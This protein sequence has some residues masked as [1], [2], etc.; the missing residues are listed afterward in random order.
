MRRWIAATLT[1][2]AVVVATPAFA[3]A[4]PADPVGALQKQ[5]VEGRGVKVSE[6]T[7]MTSDGQDTGA[8][9]RMTGVLQ[10]G[11][12]GVVASD[13]TRRVKLDAATKKIVA[14]DEEGTESL[15]ALFS[16]TRYITVKG[17]TYAKGGAFSQDLPEGKKWVSVEYA[18]EAGA[19]S[20]QVIDI[21]NKPLLKTLLKGAKSSKG[22]VY[23]GAISVKDLIKATSG[24]AVKGKLG[25]IKVEYQ[26]TVN[27]KQ[28][29]TRVVSKLTLDYGL[30]GTMATTTD[31]RYAGWGAKVSVVAPPAD[32][33][34]DAKELGE[35][36]PEVPDLLNLNGSRD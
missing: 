4:A 18:P 35:N 31:T 12:S 15:A 16:P 9:S 17:K 27:G 33:V 2:S 24:T 1:A 14:S 22:G 7:R 19:G 6:T 21:F 36:A 10:F 11:K 13:I 5:F 26:I 23:K 29:I 3:Y 32:Q 30:L 20:S 25:K 8:V 28:L 34:I